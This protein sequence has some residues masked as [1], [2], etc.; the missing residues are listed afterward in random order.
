MIFSSILCQYEI[1]QYDSLNVKFSNL[2]FNIL[3]SG[4]KNGTERILNLSSNVI[5]DSNETNF[6]HK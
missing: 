4:K 1:I 5:G 2:Q 3:K 6:L